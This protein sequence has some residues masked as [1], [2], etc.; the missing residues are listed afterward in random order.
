MLFSIRV[1]AHNPAE[2][3]DIMNG[4]RLFHEKGKFA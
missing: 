1:A 3:N 2:L 4:R